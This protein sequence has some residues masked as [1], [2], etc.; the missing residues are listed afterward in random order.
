VRA[1]I[2]DDEEPAR[3]ELRWLLDQCEPVDVCGEADSADAARRQLQES[4]LQPEVLFLDIDMPGVDGI[5]S[6]E[7]FSDLQ[8]APKIVFVTAYEEYAVDAFDVDAVDY[9]LKP[10]RLE[11]LQE[12]VERVADRLESDSESGDGEGSE[13]A[14]EPSDEER[15]LS[16]ISV[17]DEDGYRV[18]DTDEILLFESDAGDVFVETESGRFPSDFSLKFLESKLEA[19]HFYRCHRSYI[20]RVDAIENI[21]PAGAGT[22][23]LYLSGDGGVS[24]PLARSR[25]AELKRRIPWSA[26]VVEE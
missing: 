18:I 17:R 10:V 12:A 7:C 8:P 20:V 14:P 24:A 15:R 9:I 5:R 6:A 4:G 23:R 21:V 26:N 19:E 11:R 16:R 3:E 1:F 25:A 22:Y 13:E 2:V